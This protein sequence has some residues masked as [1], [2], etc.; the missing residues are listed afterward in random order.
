MNSLVEV[1]VPPCADFDNT[2]RVRLHIHPLFSSLPLVVSVLAR[3]ECAATW[4]AKRRRIIRQ[5]VE[6]LR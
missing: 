4:L 6:L 5:S 2:A 1:I 3:V